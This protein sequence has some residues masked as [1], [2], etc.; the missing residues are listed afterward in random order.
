[1]GD[2]RELSFYQKA[3][4]VIQFCDRL[5]ERWPKSMQAREIGRQMFRSASSTGANITEGHGRYEGAEYIRFLVIA[6]ASANETDH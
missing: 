1:M 4:Q 3:R 6:Q 5:I 2:Y